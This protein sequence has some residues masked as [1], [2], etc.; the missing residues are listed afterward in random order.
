MENISEKIEK[1]DTQ[2]HTH[3]HTERDRER[4]RAYFSMKKHSYFT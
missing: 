2:K 3:K 4:E 1:T